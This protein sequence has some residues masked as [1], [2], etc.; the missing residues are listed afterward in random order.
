MAFEL[1]MAANLV[2]M[3]ANYKRPSVAIKEK[4][5]HLIGI[6]FDPV[7]LLVSILKLCL[8]YV[9]FIFVTEIS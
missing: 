7:L 3:P 4:A 2:M 9:I 1:T 8:H 5:R 6:I